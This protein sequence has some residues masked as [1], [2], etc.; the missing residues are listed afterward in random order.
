MYT[1]E[2]FKSKK[3]LKDAVKEVKDGKVVKVT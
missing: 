2:N 1:V 3:T